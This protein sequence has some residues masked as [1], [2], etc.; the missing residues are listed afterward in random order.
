MTL[1]GGRFSTI[2]DEKA[3]LLN[4][5]LPVDRR[6]Y[7]QDV[8]GS[9]AWAWALCKAGILTQE[10][11]DAVAG[12]LRAVMSEL[13]SGAFA[14]SA[15][16]EDI[17]TAV[18]RRLVELIGPTGR[19]LHTG[20]S[21]NDQVATDFRMWILDT[22]PLLYAA[23]RRLQF[24]LVDL[25]ERYQEVLMPGYT[26]IQRSQPVTLAHWLMSYFW[27]L[28]RDQERL[29]DLRDRAAVMP[30]GAGALAG[31]AFPID[32][33][34][35]A[36]ALGFDAP[37]QNSIDAAADRDFAAEYLFC[38]SLAAVHM[39]RLG[40]AMTLFT[41]SEFGFF[42]LSDAYST[43]S[44]MIPQKKNPDMFELARGKAG[45]LI[46][47]LA[48]LLATLK[49]LPSAYDKDLQEDKAP[50][51]QA[52][53]TLLAILPVMAGALETM[54]VNVEKLHA[55][56]DPNLMASDLADALVRN[57]MPFREA[58]ALVGKAVR[59]ALEKGLSLQDY[60]TADWGET[61]AGVDLPKIFDPLESVNRRGV[62]G[63]TAL[64]AVR[65]QIDA[66]R[67]LLAGG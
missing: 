16:D 64:A 59:A 44:S 22:L 46:G 54:T 18:E 21:R 38:A 35:L 45:T 6:L 49:G 63:G 47:L 34:T 41:S 67:K 66:A 57:G 12:G 3:W 11:H 2:L 23:I 58:H 15:T 9:L 31:T 29:H 43:G 42:T 60:V 13:E 14:F 1:W 24:T 33:E 37:T 4:S 25:A 30:L 61:A 50:V 27:M 32:R 39:S 36:E 5:S 28:Q 8:R 55:A 40:E 48:G 52:T 17:H 26:H 10:E 20:R 19:K 7:A 62:T 53:D 56:I 51:F 65:G